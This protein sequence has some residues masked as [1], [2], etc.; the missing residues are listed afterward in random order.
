M[1]IIAQTKD[2]FLVEMSGDEIAKAAG[3]TGYYDSAWGKMNGRSQPY[4][5]SE[6]NVSAAY[7]FHSAILRSHEACKKSAGFLHGLAEML[8]H[9]MDEVIT[10][11]EKSNEGE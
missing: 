8:E 11:P 10:F 9:G 7:N 6:L 4:I 3:F 2:G 1:K 5:G